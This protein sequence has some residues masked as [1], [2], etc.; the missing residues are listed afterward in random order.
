MAKDNRVFVSL[1]NDIYEIVKNTA[2]QKKISLSKLVNRYV[3]KAIDDERKYHIDD[4]TY[5]N[6]IPGLKE[7]I[8]KA[9]NAPDS[10]FMTL[11][12]AGIDLDE[13]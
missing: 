10:E 7:D 8:L 3:N 12:E 5:I 6:S 2:K 13:V 9:K 11:E 1:D 4:T